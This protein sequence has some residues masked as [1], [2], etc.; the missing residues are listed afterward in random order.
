MPISSTKPD[1]VGPCARCGRP[2]K[3][4]KMIGSLLLGTVCR[5]K[6]LA[7]G[8]SEAVHKCPMCHSV[9]LDKHMLSVKEGHVVLEPTV[10]R[11]SL[12]EFAEE[13]SKFVP[14]PT[15]ATFKLLSVE[16]VHEDG[17]VTPVTKDEER[18]G[19][20]DDGQTTN[21]RDD[22]GGRGDGAENVPG[23]RGPDGEAEDAEEI[24]R[25]GKDTSEPSEDD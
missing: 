11:R 23:T 14:P 3:N 4:A 12:D 16:V 19:S 13:R 24:H 7:E 6:M 21:G 5:R 2:V 22:Q 20:D 17:S 8:F 18:E 25:D 10:K 9:L 1:I 15:G